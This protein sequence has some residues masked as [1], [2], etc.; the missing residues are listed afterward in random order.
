[1]AS[2]VIITNRGWYTEVRGLT[3]KNADETPLI[4]E[5]KAGW[6]TKY[7]LSPGGDKRTLEIRESGES[8]EV[9]MLEFEKPVHK[10]NF[11]TE[12]FWSKGYK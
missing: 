2:K 7:Y 4:R 5:F 10:K 11:N 12:V 8:T 9:Y 1:M 6:G 3:V